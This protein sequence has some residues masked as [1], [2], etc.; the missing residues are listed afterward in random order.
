VICVSDNNVN[1]MRFETRIPIREVMK[2][3]PAT[4]SVDTTVAL[5]A[6]KMC[7]EEVGSCIVLHNSKPAGIITEQDINCKVVAKDR[8]PGEVLVN[9]VMSTPLITADVDKTVG[10][11]VDIMVKH[12][13][14]RV[15]VVENGFVTGIVTVRDILA[16]SNEM[17]EIMANLIEIN[18]YDDIITGICDE[19]ECMS[20][21]LKS[22]DGR[23]LC[24]DCRSEEEPL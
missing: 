14:R 18:R 6:Q 4:I 17:N 21:D 8:K 10:D 24:P 22:V 3:K 15:P 2:F 23:M 20:D 11:V 9:E 13:V 5:A 16:V 12:K 19:C 7:Q 1:A